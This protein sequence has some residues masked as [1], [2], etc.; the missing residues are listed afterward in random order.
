MIPFP[1][2]ICK[3][4]FSTPCICMFSEFPINDVK[5]CHESEPKPLTANPLLKS[6]CS[7]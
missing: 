4:A 2:K 7:H 6:E 3:H 5:I 1:F